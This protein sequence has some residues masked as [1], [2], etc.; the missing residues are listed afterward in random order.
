M[1]RIMFFFLFIIELFMRAKKQMIDLVRRILVGEKI[2]FI[3]FMGEITKV[4]AFMK[5]VLPK[6]EAILDSVANEPRHWYHFWGIGKTTKLNSLSL[7]VFLSCTM[8]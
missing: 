2:A 1:V 7:I 8:C 3:V 4:I 5:M 6:I